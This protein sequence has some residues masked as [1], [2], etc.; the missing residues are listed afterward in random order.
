M[1]LDHSTIPYDLGHETTEATEATAC[2]QET[3]ATPA[4]SGCHGNL[5]GNISWGI[6]CMMI[7]G[8]KT[9]NQ[10]SAIW[11]F[12]SSCLAIQMVKIMSKPPG[13]TGFLC[14]SRGAR[15]ARRGA[16]GAVR[17]GKGEG[18]AEGAEGAE[19]AKGAGKARKLRRWKR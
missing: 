12:I 1:H 10:R 15:R 7:T 14:R 16:K 11:M 4:I 5:I 19:G 8:H 6:W 13:G 18:R 17:R 2:N 3:A 9:Y